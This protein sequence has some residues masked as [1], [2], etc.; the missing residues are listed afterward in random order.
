MKEYTEEKLE[1]KLERAK[2]KCLTAKKEYK[3][4]L[5]K[6]N[7]ILS[8]QITDILL[9]SMGL[10]FEDFKAQYNFDEWLEAF[11]RVLNRPLSFENIE[12]GQ[13]YTLGQCIRYE[14]DKELKQG[15][16]DVK[17]KLK[18][19]EKYPTINYLHDYLFKKSRVDRNDT[20]INEFEE[21]DYFDGHLRNTV[22]SAWL[23][24]DNDFLKPASEYVFSFILK[25]GNENNVTH[26]Q[27]LTLAYADCFGFLT[28][29]D[30]DRIVR[31]MNDTAVSE[32]R[33][34]NIAFRLFAT[35]YKNKPKWASLHLP[36][37]KSF[38][39]VWQQEWENIPADQFADDK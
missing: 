17:E 29:D 24:N 1:K 7:E 2:Q 39:A 38:D 6:K 16:A 30:A 10:T 12:D 33:K 31:L 5:T 13:E 22:L 34:Y 9:E 25:N 8:S 37:D 21:N 23:L 4:L 18:E 11:K 19:P 15:S 28:D 27:E 36:T 32:E 35:K 20:F 26:M 14:I 3:V